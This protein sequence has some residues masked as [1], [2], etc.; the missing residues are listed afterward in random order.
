MKFSE[1]FKRNDVIKFAA[2]NNAESTLSTLFGTSPVDSLECGC[3]NNYLNRLGPEIAG[4]ASKK[5]PL[6][7]VVPRNQRLHK[8]IVD[9][10]QNDISSSESEAPG[11][12]DRLEAFTTSRLGGPETKITDSSPNARRVGFMRHLLHH[13]EKAGMTPADV[14]VTNTQYK[15]FKEALTGL[16]GKPISTEE[17]NTPSVSMP[18]SSIDCATCEQYRTEFNNRLVSYKNKIQKRMIQGDPEVT[19]EEASKKAGELAKGV[20][21]NWQSGRNSK[22]KEE[23]GLHKLLGSWDSH[24]NESHDVTFG[25]MNVSKTPVTTTTGL[26]PGERNPKVEKTFDRLLGLS[27]G[28]ELQ[29]DPNYPEDPFVSN[30]GAPKFTPQSQPKTIQHEDEMTQHINDIIGSEWGQKNIKRE[31]RGD[32]THVTVNTPYGQYSGFEPEQEGAVENFSVDRHLTNKE[33]VYNP[34]QHAPRGRWT[35]EEDLADKPVEISDSTLNSG[36]EGKL[37]RSHRFLFQETGVNPDLT[38]LKEHG[39]AKRKFETQPSHEAVETGETTTVEEPQF[40]GK[41]VFPKSVLENSP[42]H[43]H[44][45][46]LIAKHDALNVDE[47]GKQRT[48]ETMIPAEEVLGAKQKAWKE[49]LD[50]LTGKNTGGYVDMPP[51]T[52]TVKRN[53]K[54]QEEFFPGRS[55]VPA[56]NVPGEY[57]Q[58]KHSEAMK[59]WEGLFNQY[60]INSDGSTENVTGMGFVPGNIRTLYQQTKL[61]KLDESGNQIVKKTTVPVKKFVQIP[62]EKRLPEPVLDTDAARTNY[63]KSFETAL[64]ARYPGVDREKAEQMLA[65]DHANAVRQKTRDIV[66]SPSNIRSLAKKNIVAST[67]NK[68]R[69]MLT[70]TQEIPARLSS[71]EAAKAKIDAMK[72]QAPCTKCGKN[73]ADDVECKSNVMERRRQQAAEAAYND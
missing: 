32:R 36:L 61:P 43:E 20:F 73:C 45:K 9:E 22:I 29:T 44:L 65:E 53:G 15:R 10:I 3:D 2:E 33:Q 38:V 70:K 57:I 60:R 6:K 24:Q 59:P 54:M 56:E 72:N 11:R 12:N 28:W 66:E 64:S 46:D 8:A 58:R 23:K 34:K 49:K 63:V 27:K 48:T 47:N 39:E 35:T 52:V 25:S 41:V 37:P 30:E 67:I 19:E 71:I 21:D 5:G 62:E 14:G 42:V 26:A 7:D 55:R 68:A 4:D 16:T 69:Q 50:E 17:T 51:E 31:Q 13:V 18:H 1:I 40:E